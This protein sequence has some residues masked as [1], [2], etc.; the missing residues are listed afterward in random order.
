MEHDRENGI[1]KDGTGYKW[2]LKDFIFA[3]FSAVVGGLN[4]FGDSS[5]ASYCSRYILSAR[6]L[7]FDAEP[8]LAEQNKLDGYDYYHRAIKYSDNIAFACYKAFK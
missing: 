7:T 3:P 2:K 1:L 6:Q 5:S 4:A 8:F